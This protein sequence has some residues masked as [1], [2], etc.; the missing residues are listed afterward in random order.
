M[1]L[2]GDCVFP[3]LEGLHWAPEPSDVFHHVR[4]FLAP[5][6]T[7]PTLRGLET[8]S[9]LSILSSLP[10]RCRFL[11]KVGV[12]IF[13]DTWDS[14][15][16]PVSI[17]VRRLVHLKSSSVAGLDQPGLAHLAQL[18]DLKELRLRCPLVGRTP[19]EIF[20]LPPDSFPVLEKMAMLS[21]AT[22]YVTELSADGT[23]SRQF[24]SALAK[25]IS[26][27]SLQS[28]SR[29]GVH[30]FPLVHATEDQIQL[31]AIHADTIRP[32]FSFH[33]LELVVIAHPVGFDLDAAVI[34]DLARSWPHLECLLLQARG[35]RSIQSRVTLE[36]IYHLAKHC[37]GLRSLEISFDATAVPKIKRQTNEKKRVIQHSLHTLN[38]ALSPIRNPTRI[39]NF[40]SA[41]FAELTEIETLHEEL[42][43]SGEFSDD[44]NAEPDVLASQEVWK[45]VEGFL[46]Y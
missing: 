35:Y 43:Y 22:E 1:S 46:D 41:I 39:A 4:L 23:H 44:E 25:N 3:S 15:H 5:R 38:V 37:P 2:P 13:R 17:F 6:I 30:R 7:D 11:T 9:H 14:V 45:K 16:E 33:N 12:H 10:V 28:L 27:S 24:Y 18:P 26:H 36:G 34:C 32:L 31:Y 20:T 19:E 40:L 8:D 29:H 42:T 21:S